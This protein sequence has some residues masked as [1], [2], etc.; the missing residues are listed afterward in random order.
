MPDH[1]AGPPPREAVDYLRRKGVR[2]GFSYEDVW[3]EEHGF[4]FTV[5]KMMEV[6]LLRDV[7]TSL[8]RAQAE[9]TTFEAWRQE[10]AEQLSKRGWWGRREVVDPKTGK[11][12]V[13][14]LGSSR[15]LDTIWRVNMGQSSQAGRWERAQRS[16][17]PWLI[18]RVGPSREHREQHLAWDGLVLRKDDPFWATHNPRNGWGCKC[19]SRAVSEAQMRRYRRDGIPYPARGDAPPRTGKPV[20]TEL[21]DDPSRAD[22]APAPKRMT[23]VNKRTGE[24]HTGYE[25]IDPGFEHNPGVGRERQLRTQWR[26]RDRIFAGQ[27]EPDPQSTP[28][29]GAVDLS[30]DKNPVNELRPNV[31]E[32]LRAIE[33]VHGDGKLPTVLVRE[34]DDEDNKFGRYLPA[35]RVE[36]YAPDAP[37]GAEPIEVRDV[38]PGI[39]LFL[40]AIGDP[41]H[42]PTRPEYWPALTMA[43]ETGH[44]LDDAGLGRESQAQKT[45]EMQAVMQKI[46]ASPHACPARQ[47]GRRIL[48]QA[49][50][51]VGAR[52]RSMGGLAQRLLDAQGRAG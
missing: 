47:S 31:Q 27:M 10:M 34:V 17:L 52:L 48:A 39:F 4:A 29:R 9:G 36:I 51:A 35:R 45:P 7:Q 23:Y 33:R 21:A 46:T 38:P 1:P 14:Q 18:Y 11:T 42:T 26:D 16:S 50:R 41:P 22:Q 6:D 44:F 3:R 19:T 13:A 49:E 20:K 5:A 30:P 24:V 28:V 32:A 15:R 40:Q 2:T 43:H 37:P 25:G 12:V 8:V